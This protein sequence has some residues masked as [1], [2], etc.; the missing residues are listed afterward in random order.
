MK[1][2]LAAVA[3]LAAAVASPLLGQGDNED[4]R[5]TLAGLNGVYIYVEEIKDEVQ[6]DG[7]SQSQT[8]TDVELR[9]RQAGITVLTREHYLSMT[10]TGVLYVNVN[11]L[12]NSPDLYTYTADVEVQLRQPVRLIRTPSVTVFATP[13]WSVAV[14]SAGAT[15]SSIRDHVRDATDRFINAYLAANPKR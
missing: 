2:V 4:T 8:Q 11:A 6:R 14:L 3:L 10:G 1:T 5:K 13:T 12:K 9:L 15:V 7:L